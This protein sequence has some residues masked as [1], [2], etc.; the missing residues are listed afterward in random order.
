MKAREKAYYLLCDIVLG[1]KYSNLILRKEINEFEAKD[2][3]LITSIVYGTL[4]NYRYLRYQWEHF[5]HDSISEDM[6]LLMDMSIYQ[7]LMMDKVP[8]YA[9]VNEA[10]EIAKS[11]HKGKYRAMINAMLR[12]FQRDGV[13][14]LTGNEIQKL[15]L[16]TSHPE[17]IVKMWEK[18][19]GFETA[20]AIC[21]DNQK[22]AH[23][24]ARVNTRVTSREAIIEQNPLFSKGFLSQDALI[25]QGGNIADTKEYLSGQ[26]SIQDEASQ[27]VALF[28]DPKP[29]EKVLD[30]CAAPGTKTCHIAQIMDDQGEVIAL[31]IH[32]HRV[33]LI[34]QGALR[35]GMHSVKAYCHD[36]CE[37]SQYYDE[38]SFDR[39]LVDAPCSGY[40]VMKRKND[41]KVHMQPE[42][43]DEIIQLQKAI[44]NEACKMVKK[45]G[46]LVYSTCTL[47]KKE[48][49]K[50]V[51][52]FIKEHPDFE[53]L[54]QKTIFPFTFD[55]DGFFMAKLIHH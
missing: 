30:T 41:I 5:V 43:M 13:R 6:A 48:N 15:A 20:K 10:V 2:K 26:I 55:T 22:V 18:Q 21:E 47:N 36:A 3:A 7:L 4:Q 9:V 38:E 51:E 40:G 11:V 17:W 45:E 25:Y 35:Q 16:K 31:D 28:L 23:Q 39:V 8:S 1:K 12:R 50:Q 44:L 49:E 52:N 42:D 24:C 14:E 46:I 19:Y 29:G 27:C 32:E 33:E 37:V 54:E 34:K 53:L